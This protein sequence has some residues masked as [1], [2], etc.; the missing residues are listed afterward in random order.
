MTVVPAGERS[1]YARWWVWG[2]GTAAVGGAGAYF[3][4]EARSGADQLQQLNKTSPDH[5][6]TEATA[7]EAT[8]RDHVLYFNIGMGVAGALAL[9]T[10]ILYM[11]EPK[12][13]TEVR[14]GATP[15]HG[16]AAVVLGG[17]F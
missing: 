1:W 16:G 11:T 2:L 15:M 12:A 14:I 17:A 6:F 7:L 13:H 10:A 5:K 3:G 8:T 4:W 9:T